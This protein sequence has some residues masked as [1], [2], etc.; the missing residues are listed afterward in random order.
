M[1][2]NVGKHRKEIILPKPFAV[3]GIIISKTKP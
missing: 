1:T 2:Y 3:V